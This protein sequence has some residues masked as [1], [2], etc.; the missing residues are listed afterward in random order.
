MGRVVRARCCGARPSALASQTDREA[1]TN[2]AATARPPTRRSLLPTTGL[3]E[4]AADWGSEVSATN[5]PA[6]VR[7]AARRLWPNRVHKPQV[8]YLSASLCAELSAPHHVTHWF[9]F[10]PRP[11]R[12]RLGRSSSSP[13]KITSHWSVSLAGIFVGESQHGTGLVRGS[14]FGCR[15]R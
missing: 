12:S 9:S 11:R 3:S 10:S 6:G 7:A 15:R 13:S 8:S 2:K 5:P 14:H 4:G 1:T